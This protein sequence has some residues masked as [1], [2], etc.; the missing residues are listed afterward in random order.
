LEEKLYAT[1]NKLCHT[2]VEF[3]EKTKELNNPNLTK[4]YVCFNEQIS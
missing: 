3:L 1:E 4:S 2:R